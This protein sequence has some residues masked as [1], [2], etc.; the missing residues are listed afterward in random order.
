[1]TVLLSDPPVRTL[2][3]RPAA[4]TT[5]PRLAAW[6]HGVTAPITESRRARLHAR[7]GGVVALLALLGYLTWRVLATL[8]PSGPWRAAA[9]LLVGFEA[10]PLIGSVTKLASWWTI[11][12]PAPPPVTE[13]PGGMRLAVLIPT[14]NES[15]EIVGPTIVAARELQ[16]EHE[17]W[18]LD[19]GD[20]PWLEQMCRELGVR[21]V[22]RPEHDHAKAGN[23]N[24]A[25]DV[26]AREE[27]AG[28]GA[29][30]LVAILD[31]DHVP[32]PAF[33]TSTLG[34][35]ADDRIGL[36][37]APQTFFNAGAFDD[38][39][40]TGEQG[41][42]FNVQLAAR[43]HAGAGT[44]WCGS[45][46]VLRVAAL[47]EVGGVAS[48]TVTEDMH[49]TLKLQRA[50]WRT[51]YHHQNVA[52]GLAPATPE[53]YLV[54][55]R[56]WGLG[57][58][59][60]AVA[61]KLW[62]RQQW[63]SWRTQLEYVLG[64]LWWLEGLATVFT[65]AIPVALLLTGAATS[66]APP[67][68]FM[69][70]FATAF[71]VRMCGY[72][73]L[74]RRQIRWRTAF[75]LRVLRVPVG[76]ACLWWLLT[77]RTLSFAV[78]PK[79]AHALRS[80]GRAPGV[81]V[82]LLV[83]CLGVVGYAVLG[84]LGLVPWHTSSASTVSAGLWVAIATAVLAHAVLRIR[85]ERYSTSRRAAHRFPLRMQVQ[86]DGIDADLLDLSVSGAAVRMRLDAPVVFGEVS[87]QLP[88][89]EP[90]TMFATPA[91]AMGT[92]VVTLSAPEH[93]W[94]TL[95]A[96]SLWLFHTPH[97]AVPGLRPGV[98]VVAIQNASVR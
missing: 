22:R 77:R 26:M 61:E 75:A 1:M 59:Q 71:T 60:V 3:R 13:P 40:Y 30:D 90:V 27:A 70:V 64:T 79:G 58:M 92:R 73:A 94:T 44:F 46:S 4:T 84:Y 81:V 83:A 89:T 53:Q 12:V 17:T 36:V 62:R 32:L 97:G 67:G 5:P 85:S 87:F 88:G 11:D 56:R 48:E 31:C 91:P 45:T 42:F 28:G 80:R 21:Y 23:L 34:Y 76:L 37:Q 82:L 54:Q 9:W 55:R 63:M 72:K 68:E 38:D 29:I 74:L 65:L 86:V 95:R 14:F 20:R 39:G 6:A 49:T 19:D 47:R 8:P 96:L 66:T 16:P 50:G 18:V 33:L 51:A 69:A 2:E 78:T 35:F 15:A 25:L 7:V 57:A 93:C 24:H 41:L 43:Q 52:L 10:L 98:P